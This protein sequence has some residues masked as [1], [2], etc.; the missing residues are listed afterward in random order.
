MTSHRSQGAVQNGN[1]KIC[2]NEKPDRREVVSH[3]LEADPFT[4]SESVQDSQLEATPLTSSLSL[5]KKQV[6]LVELEPRTYPS[7]LKW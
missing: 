6:V 7:A 2:D 1:L 5:S 3:E 4:S